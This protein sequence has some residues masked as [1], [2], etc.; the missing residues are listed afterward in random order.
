MPS[1]TGGSVSP[2]PLDVLSSNPT[3]LQGQTPW[4]FPVRLSDPQAGRPDVGLEPSQ[5]REDFGVIVTQFM[6]HPLA[7]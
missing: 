6:G 4:G 2:S 3:G 1:G 5:Q 7:E